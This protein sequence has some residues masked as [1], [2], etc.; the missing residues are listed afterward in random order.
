MLV[1]AINSDRAG[2]FFKV[3]VRESNSE[4][5][6]GCADT[7]LNGVIV[8]ME[9]LREFFVFFDATTTDD[10]IRAKVRQECLHDTLAINDEAR[11]A[12]KN[13]NAHDN[14]NDRCAILL[15][16]ALQVFAR[17]D[18]ADTKVVR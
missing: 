7:A 11:Q 10:V 5:R 12:N 4:G 16:A 9:F 6:A 1:I 13:R 14:R 3:I 18:A 2:I 15:T 8:E 17:D